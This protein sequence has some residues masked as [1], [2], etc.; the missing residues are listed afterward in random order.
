RS[1]YP[2]L[3]DAQNN[4]VDGG[5]EV[6][7]DTPAEKS[8][9]RLFDPQPHLLS[10]SGDNSDESEDDG[11]Y[12]VRTASRRGKKR[13]APR[14]KQLEPFS[15]RSLPKTQKELD[16]FEQKIRR[17]QSR[18]E[19]KKRRR[20]QTS[21]DPLISD[22][23]ELLADDFGHMFPGQVFT[24]SQKVL[25]QN[26]EWKKAVRENAI[27]KEFIALETND[28]INSEHIIEATLTG[29]NKAITSVRM[30]DATLLRHLAE[31]SGSPSTFTRLRKKKMMASTQSVDSPDPGAA[32]MHR[33]TH[34]SDLTSTQRAEPET[35]EDTDDVSVSHRGGTG[36]VA[37]DEALHEV[38]QQA[39]VRINAEQDSSSRQNDQSTPRNVH[40]TREDVQSTF[41]AGSSTSRGPNEVDFQHEHQ[42]PLQQQEAPDTPQQAQQQQYRAQTEP[43]PGRA[44]AE[45]SSLF[46][47]VGTITGNTLAALS[48]FR[49]ARRNPQER[50]RILAQQA[51]T[52]STTEPATEATTES[53]TEPTI[54]PA[55]DIAES[56]A[57]TDRDE[58]GVGADWWRDGA[59]RSGTYPSTSRPLMNTSQSGTQQVANRSRGTSPRWSQSVQ[60]PRSRTSRVASHG[61]SQASPERASAM[62]QRND[63]TAPQTARESRTESLEER[64]MQA[65]S[66]R[67]KERARSRVLAKRSFEAETVDEQETLQKR[68]LSELD[69]K[70]KRK[71]YS[72]PGAFDDSQMDDTYI[73]ETEAW[74]IGVP[75]LRRPGEKLPA[76]PR[77]AYIQAEQ[78]FTNANGT[79]DPVIFSWRHMLCRAMYQVLGAPPHLRLK[80]FLMMF[81]NN[82]DK[83]QLDMSS[84]MQWYCSD[85]E[86]WKR[87]LP[88][89]SSFSDFTSANRI[90]LTKAYCESELVD[91]E[92]LIFH[93]RFN[94]SQTYLPQLPFDST[95]YM[96]ETPKNRNRSKSTS[97]SRTSGKFVVP[98]T[99][100]DDSSIYTPSID[101][102]SEQV[103]IEQRKSGHAKGGS[104]FTVP[105][106]SD[107]DDESTLILDTPS[108]PPP[109][110]TPAHATLPGVS[111]PATSPRPN[112]FAAEGV[113]KKR[114]STGI[115]STS[116][117]SVSSTPQDAAASIIA[118]APGVARAHP[119]VIGLASSMAT[120]P[121]NTSNLAGPPLIAS[122][123]QEK[124]LRVATA[125]TLPKLTQAISSPGTSP[126]EDRV[127]PVT[128]TTLA[129]ER[130]T[131][132]VG[133]ATLHGELAEDRVAVATP[134]FSSPPSRRLSI[135][136]G[137][138]G[139]VSKMLAF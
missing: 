76:L 16:D 26:A 127:S 54:E 125:P 53:A 89:F 64:S 35:D 81:G 52:Q 126:E 51:P 85:E 92:N 23:Q 67:K 98:D 80:W 71:R 9:S 59:T 93:R 14:G 43:R 39:V 3:T 24:F 110:P 137:G 31:R 47:R 10:N 138:E 90:A 108:K 119:K 25:F 111:A 55:T 19:G 36:A 113:D 13:E 109:R 104:T 2:P 95:T 83:Q 21:V 103:K 78:I 102:N 134:K 41:Q 77:R 136:E 29:S 72:M 121:K 11:F 133:G 112:I 73:S 86:K 17:S 8:R 129:E 50:Q 74:P 130:L 100:D 20:F 132:V 124:D 18:R 28:N 61:P 62:Q 70:S 27:L 120:K 40:S 128:P 44:V 33:R 99:D 118:A 91:V 94:T 75:D 97:R 22:A 131:W 32:N 38:L 101:M 122:P 30:S 88:G 5:K 12:A 69:G 57:S 42:L 63:N 68:G 84:Y 79:T 66:M 107:D 60:R 46:R 96:D 82:S 37:T 115:P 49:R 6:S 87:W 139:A 58:P 114:T 4:P 106:D 15:R 45:R 116:R 123:T 135:D 48:P 105:E 65:E 7:G 1:R 117:P 34:P 56:E